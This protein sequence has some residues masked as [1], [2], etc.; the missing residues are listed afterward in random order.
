MSRCHIDFLDRQH[1]LLNCSAAENARLMVI[2]ELVLLLG[3]F[4]RLEAA[5]IPTASSLEVLYGWFRQIST[6]WFSHDHY[7]PCLSAEWSRHFLGSRTSLGR[8]AVV[9]GISGL[10]T[11]PTRG[12]RRGPFGSPPCRRRTLLCHTSKG[13]FFRG[14][15]ASG[16]GLL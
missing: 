4:L 1:R 6:P 5:P 10:T 15:L 13:I 3:L 9:H 11:L 8:W 16:P 12:A 7:R 14:R 2:R